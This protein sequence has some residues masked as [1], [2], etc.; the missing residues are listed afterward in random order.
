MKY[1]YACLCVRVCVKLST[2]SHSLCCSL[3]LLQTIDKMSSDDDAHCALPA[4]CVCKCAC[5]CVWDCLWIVDN[6]V[7]SPVVGNSNV[8]NTAAATTTTTAVVNVP[9]S[10]TRMLHPAG[11]GRTGVGRETL[12]HACTLFLFILLVEWL[13]VEIFCE[14]FCRCF[15]HC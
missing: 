6:I 1:L 3:L 15:A 4:V 8:V 13:L 9:P 2:L 10:L 7:S 11:R 14:R 12:C 5:A